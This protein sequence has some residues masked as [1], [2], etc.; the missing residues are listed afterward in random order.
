VPPSGARPLL[1]ATLIVRDEAHQLA[2]CLASLDGV[3]DEVVVYDTGS[4]DG[5]PELARRAGARVLE[6]YWDDD[7][8]RARTAA[9]GMTSAAWA[10][11]LDADERMVAD[12]AVLRGL[13]L[14]R[15]DGLLLRVVNRD[16][17]GTFLSDHP[18]LRIVRTAGARWEG[19]VHEVL[20]LPDPEGLRRCLPMEIASVQHLGYRDGA[21]VR[22]KAER[23]LRLCQLE[24]DELH[25]AGSEDRTAGA[26][27]LFNLARS[28]L[29]LDRRQLA[30]DALEALR[31][32]VA[33]GPQRTAATGLLAQ[34]LLDTDGLERAA[35]V[36][37]AELRPQVDARFA[38]WL[39]A[40]AMAR[41]GRPAEALTLLRR[42]DRLVD[43]AGVEKPL[44]PVL[45][46][47]AVLAA[48]QG[49]LEEARE[50]LLGAMLDHG[51]ITGNGPL[52]RALFADAPDALDH[53]LRARTVGTAH[54]RYLPAVLAEL[55]RHR[56]APTPVAQVG[57]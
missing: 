32:I 51:E 36:L 35:L 3:V 19:R 8:G 18:S 49:R 15:L 22:R 43:A 1:A 5:T 45:R 21:T 7:F 37:E 52:L 46:A 48:G 38:D 31:E 16:G 11:C 56:D 24:L 28:A 34:I 4:I 20:L 12:A 47:R 9:L 55:D 30:V 54:P 23:N 57:P 10:L 29:E 2:D 33:A 26:R 50:A 41:L 42:I 13:L 6:G 14:G 40:Q 53:R 17:R 39:L 25:A 27:V 44:G